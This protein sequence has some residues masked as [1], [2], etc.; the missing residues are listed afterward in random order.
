MAIG[1]AQASRLRLGFAFPRD[2][3]NV[4]LRPT[5]RRKR[6][7]GT[8]LPDQSLPDKPLAGSRHG[9]RVRLPS[10]PRSAMMF[11]R[12]GRGLALLDAAAAELM[13]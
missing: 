9:T 8:A 5:A 10:S 11:H 12:R 1:Q 4:A 3:G 6:A 7:P 13:A 2:A